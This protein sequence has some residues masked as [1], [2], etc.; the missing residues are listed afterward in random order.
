MAYDTNKIASLLH[1]K[2]LINKIKETFAAKSDITAL[3][4]RI[5]TL[6]NTV[7]SQNFTVNN[8][9]AIAYKTA[10]SKTFAQLPTS[11]DNS[12]PP[13][14][15]QS[16]CGNVYNV[17]DAFTTTALFVEGAGKSCLAGTNVVVVY[18]NG[19]YKYDIL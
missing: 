14:A 12:V 11:F 1:I 13:Y 7:Y 18:D 2:T 17:T 9:L 6:E 10:G 16:L 8:K 4:N 5:S 3:N 15:S 19:K